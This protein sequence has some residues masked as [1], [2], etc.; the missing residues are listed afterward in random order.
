MYIKI[1][2]KIDKNILRESLHDY[3]IEFEE[4]DP[5]TAVCEDIM[6]DVAKNMN[7][8]SLSDED[9]KASCE[10]VLDLIIRKYDFADLIQCMQDYLDANVQEKFES[11]F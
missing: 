9:F 11:K 3:G 1:L 6:Q 4:T 7:D 10:E 5:Y 2:N 8:G